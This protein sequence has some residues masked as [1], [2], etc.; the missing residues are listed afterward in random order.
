MFLTHE[1]GEYFRPTYRKS[2]QILFNEVAQK[3]TGARRIVIA[4]VKFAENN[5]LQE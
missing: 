5:K 2:K 1:A 3:L 4:H